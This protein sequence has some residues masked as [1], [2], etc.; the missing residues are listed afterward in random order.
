[1]FKWSKEFEVDNEDINEQHKN[2]FELGND[3]FES[4][5]EDCKPLVMAMF[6]YARIHFMLEEEYMKEINFAG[7]EDHKKAHALLIHKLNKATENQITNKFEFEEVQKLIWVWITQ[8]IMKKD[9]EYII[10]KEK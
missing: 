2:L 7:L 6:K 10:K 4:N 5:Y 9:K 1:M 3:I 8:H